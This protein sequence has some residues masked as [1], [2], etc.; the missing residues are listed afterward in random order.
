MRTKRVNR[1]YCDFCKKAG[2]SKFHM[3]KHEERCTLNP[4]RVCRMCE[5]SQGEQK[6]MAELL[7]LLPELQ[8]EPE[9]SSEDGHAYFHPDQTGDVNDALK[10]LRKATGNCPVCILAALRQKKLPVYAATDFDFA[11][12]M[13][14]T[15]DT[16]NA[17]ERDNR[18]SCYAGADYD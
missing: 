6:P 12:E 10:A 8:T 3:A 11:A 2:Q 5:L 16:I 4:C 7:A 18:P 17:N 13:K 9:I 14:A 15:W 1:Y